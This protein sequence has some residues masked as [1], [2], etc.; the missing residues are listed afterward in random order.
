MVSGI[1]FYLFHERKTSVKLEQL[2]SYLI[3]DNIMML[4]H[5]KLFCYNNLILWKDD[6]AAMSDNTIMTQIA[7][8]IL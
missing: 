7:V 8:C 4:W 6:F 2:V 1:P 5:C 3:A